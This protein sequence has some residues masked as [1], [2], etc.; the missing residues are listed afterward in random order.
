MRNGWVP[1]GS[2]FDLEMRTGWQPHPV[3]ISKSK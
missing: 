1:S 3:V 2:H